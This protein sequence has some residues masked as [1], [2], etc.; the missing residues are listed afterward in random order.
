[1]VELSIKARFGVHIRRFRADITSLAHLHS[2]LLDVFRS[3]RLPDDICIKYKDDEGEWVTCETEDEWLEALQMLNSQQQQKQQPGVLHV[4]ICDV[5]LW[6]KVPSYV[7]VCDSVNAQIAELSEVL[8]KSFNEENETKFKTTLT[9]VVNTI[10]STFS[11]MYSRGNAAQD[12][13]Q[14]QPEQKHEEPREYTLDIDLSADIPVKVY[15]GA[16]QTSS[17]S[18]SFSSSSSSSATAAVTDSIVVPIVSSSLP[19]NDEASRILQEALNP[20]APEI[21]TESLDSLDSDTAVENDHSGED[22]I[23]VRDNDQDASQTQALAPASAEP[24]Q[25][26]DII[27]DPEEPVV[28][29]PVVEEP[30][31]EAP[32]VEEPVVEE[33]VVEEP[34]VEEPVVEA[35]AVEEPVAEE[36]AVEEP[37]VEEPVAEP[38]IEPAVEEPAQPE[39]EPE[40]PQQPIYTAQIS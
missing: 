10:K 8:K 11:S 26:E 32:A 34:A 25:E 21:D 12:E 36:S 1:M 23:M 13:E 28:E 33:P 37:V 22:W 24:A 7:E 4:A 6:E 9:D 39:P 5:P 15:P 35:P 18:A 17:V 30:V 40:A 3:Y 16:P 29:E 20:A 2:K 38:V 31:V 27:P 19:E 14:P